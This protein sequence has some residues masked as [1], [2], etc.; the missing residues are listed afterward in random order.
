M[1]GE[2]ADLCFTSPPYGQQRDYGVAKELVQ[3]WDGLMR[4]VFANLPMSDDGQVLV[5]LGLIHRDGEWLP[6]WDGWIEW[7]REQGWRRFGWYVWDQGSG[8]PGDWSGRFAPSFEFV[9]HFNLESVK[10][11]QVHQQKSGKRRRHA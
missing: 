11:E 6:Y 7:M 2:K 3:D 4:G 1:D 10:P 9:F 8:L 5:N